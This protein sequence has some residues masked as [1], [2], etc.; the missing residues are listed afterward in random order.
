MMNG[1][2]FVVFDLD[3]VLVDIDSSWQLVHR[4]FNTDNEENFVRYLRKEIDFKEFMRSDIR[5]WNRAPISTIKS[6]LDSAPLMTGA[7]ETIQT[8]KERRLEPLI[9]SSGISVLADRIAQELGIRLVYANRLVVDENGKLSGEGEEVVPLDSK[10]MVLR[11]AMR[12]Y[13]SRPRDCITV[14][15][16]RHDIPFFRVSGLSIAFNAKDE[17]TRQAADVN[18]DGRDLRQIL[19]WVTGQ[20]P[21]KG[22]VSL[23]LGREE[24]EAVA[25]SLSPDNLKVPSGLSVRTFRKGSKVIMKVTSLKRVDTMLATL[26][27]LLASAELARGAINVARDR[28]VSPR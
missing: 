9:V 19:P 27:D 24:A 7:I 2:R 15:D 26:D 23:D 6:I 22:L 20:R 28:V 5:L 17:K 25:L 4:R 10:D 16:S 8:I 13:D 18:V 14:G 12:K 21:D 1:L 11:E 3:G